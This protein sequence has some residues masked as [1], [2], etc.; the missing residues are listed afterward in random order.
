MIIGVTKEVKDG[1]TRVALTPD[2]VATLIRSGH[3][4]L[5][6]KNAGIASG[7]TD[8]MYRDSGATIL[9]KAPDVWKKSQLLVKVKE[10]LA[11]EYK[12]FHPDLV[13]FTYLHLAGVP[14]L[15]RSLCQKGVTALGYETVELPDGQLP[16][17]TPMSE[18][19][20]RVAAQVGTRLL[21]RGSNGQGKGILL[22]GVTGTKRGV[23]TVI[24]GGVVGVKAA[25]VA[26]GMGAEVVI[27]DISKE[28]REKLQQYYGPRATI[29]APS[30][31]LLTQWVK[32]SDL[33]I[34]AVLVAGD[35]APKV[36]TKRM[37]Q[38]MEPGSVIVDVAIDQGGCVETARPT[39]HKQPTYLKYGIIHYCV[40]NMPALTPMTSTEGLT[41]AT[42]PY[43][44]QIAE[45]GLEAALARNPAL[46][47]GLQ[48]N[49]GKVVHP[50]VA[51][52]FRS[53]AA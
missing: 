2:G 31:D 15:T 26:V 33:L 18:V 28:R 12:Y 10:P 27:F 29:L 11:A 49:K 20:G 13:L 32:K 30:T 16:L 48:I 1:E 45:I 37:V 7:F 44:H 36:I 8:R 47:K 42:F 24:G 41:I 5:V 19:A 52:L 23:V 50:V 6:E 34:G 17:L 46:A 3:T 38:Q 25:D 22:G 4:V 43:I 51:K 40:T 9:P 53:L 21:H 39:T 14:P 35:K